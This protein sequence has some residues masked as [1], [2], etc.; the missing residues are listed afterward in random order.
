MRIFADVSEEPAVS[1]FRVEERKRRI[2]IN[3]L[4]IIRCPD[5]IRGDDSE[6]ELYFRVYIGP[7]SAGFLSEHAARAQPPKHGLK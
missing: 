2:V 3:A 5:F 1:I 7:K 6:I 4:A